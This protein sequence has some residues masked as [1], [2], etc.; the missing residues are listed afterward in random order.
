MTD[1]ILAN[2]KITDVENGVPFTLYYGYNGTRYVTRDD[3]MD[4]ESEPM[5]ITVTI[6]Y[7]QEIRT[8]KNSFT[9]IEEESKSLVVNK[10]SIRMGM[11]NR[12]IDVVLEPELG[13]K[14]RHQNKYLWCC[15]CDSSLISIYP[16]T[17]AMKICWDV[18]SEMDFTQVMECRQFTEGHIRLHKSIIHGI[19]NSMNQELAER[20]LEYRC[21]GYKAYVWDHIDQEF[22][23]TMYPS[24]CILIEELVN[25][26]RLELLRMIPLC[27]RIMLVTHFNTEGKHEIVAALNHYHKGDYKDPRRDL[28]L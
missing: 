8:F 19:V 13:E 2:I 14:K 12:N 1:N 10:I 24:V 17:Y 18:L 4:F 23:D 26:N 21:S 20:C 22:F 28:M 27:L 15:T 3:S 11:H 5:E 6:N 16:L 9:N 7:H 25:N